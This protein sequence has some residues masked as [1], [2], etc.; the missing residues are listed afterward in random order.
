MNRR[1]LARLAPCLGAATLLLLLAAPSGAQWRYVVVN[2]QQLHPLQVERLER[3]YCSPIAD[4]RYWYNSS[5]GIW[6][7]EGD[8]RPQGRFVYRC[9]WSTNAQGQ[10]R[11]L[12][13][14]GLLYSTHEIIS[15]RP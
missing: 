8:P 14:R 2:G 15:G 4:G 13:E 7:Y 6:G 10:R 11:S 5:T 12:S 9:G 1:I 3:L